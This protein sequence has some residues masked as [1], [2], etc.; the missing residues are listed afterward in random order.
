MKKYK[1]NSDK[2]ITLYNA[3]NDKNDIFYKTMNKKRNNQ[4]L[5]QFPIKKNN[6]NGYAKK[7]NIQFCNNNSLHH[8]ESNTIEFPKLRNSHSMINLIKINHI[9]FINERKEI[10]NNDSNNDNNYIINY[11]NKK[12]DLSINKKREIE[13]EE[14]RKLSKIKNKYIDSSK[15]ILEEPENLEEEI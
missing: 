4:I 12:N 6:Y 14:E 15:E 10:K 8:K 3:A 2:Y 1:E 7:I 5:H 11:K 13:K 9:N